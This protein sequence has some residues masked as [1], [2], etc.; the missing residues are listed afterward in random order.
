MS[1]NRKNISYRQRKA[2]REAQ[3]QKPSDKYNS[4]CTHATFIFKCY[5]TWLMPNYLI[6]NPNLE[7]LLGRH[8]SGNAKT[9]RQLERDVVVVNATLAEIAP[10][11]KEGHRAGP[12]TDE[13]GCEAF[14]HLTGHLIDWCNYLR[15]PS[16]FSSDRPIPIVGLREINA[17]A[18]AVHRIAVRDGYVKKLTTRKSAWQ[19]LRGEGS[20][21]RSVAS[22]NS[23]MINFI[24]AEHRRR[25]HRIR[26]ERS[27]DEFRVRGF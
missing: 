13:I 8:S 1:E 21:G 18:E 19:I 3:K 22:Y 17:L 24:E 23:S 7:R 10:L 27:L 6:R 4:K 20:G 15:Q 11:F 16:L 25:T 14:Y 2:N 12:M 9:D 5:R 26:S